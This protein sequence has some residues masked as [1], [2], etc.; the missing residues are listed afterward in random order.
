MSRLKKKALNKYKNFNAGGSKCPI[1]NKQFRDGCKHS[2]VEV[3][4][5]LYENYIKTI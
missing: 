1:C 5:R 4:E 3:K 2:V